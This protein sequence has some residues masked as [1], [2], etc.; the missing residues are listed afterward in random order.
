MRSIKYNFQKI[1]TWLKNINRIT[2]III[3]TAAVYIVA[4][5]FNFVLR[6]IKEKDIILF[7]FPGK[8]K[9]IIFILF[10]SI[11][12]APILETLLNQSLPYYILNKIKYFKERSY[13]ILLASALFFGLLHFYSL[14]YI[15]YAFLLGLLFMYGY[16][17][18][19]KTDKKTFYLIAISHFLVNLGIFI[20]NLF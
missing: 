15:F 9:S 20:R 6:F 14:F 3:L 7:D 17:I 16:M 2:F 19:I 8:D 5:C 11:V 13:L 10:S 12:L 4:F 1:N 18:R